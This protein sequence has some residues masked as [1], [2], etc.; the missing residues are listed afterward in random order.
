LTRENPVFKLD[1]KSAVGR[2]TK[3]KARHM[4]AKPKIRLDSIEQAHRALDALPQHQPTEL[5]KA[6]AIQKLLG[7]IRA[8]Q[9]KGYSLAAIGKVLSDSGI[10]ITPGALR[11]YVGG[12]KV[13]GGAKRRVKRKR[14]DNQPKNAQ[15]SVPANTRGAAPTQPA[16]SATRPVTASPSEDPD[17]DPTARLVSAAA[18]PGGS[19]RAGFYVRPDREKI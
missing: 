19:P 15:P 4:N 1:E 8:S 13:G 14:A 12:S 17:W 9:A 16:Q 3:R 5:T 6:Q 10:P 18:S 11:L 7:P 2:E